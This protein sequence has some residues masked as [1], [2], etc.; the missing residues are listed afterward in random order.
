MSGKDTVPGG[1][2]NYSEDALAT[3]ARHA[4][5]SVDGLYFGSAHSVGIIARL[6]RARAES[7]PVVKVTNIKG[8]HVSYDVDIFVEYGRRITQ[9]SSLV[10]K[11]VVEELHR[12]T[13][14]NAIVNVHIRG[15]K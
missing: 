12:L 3:I 9:V 8:R 14:L 1:E 2:L 11:A 5:R 10:Q 7:G 6:T 13:G 4:C 15:I